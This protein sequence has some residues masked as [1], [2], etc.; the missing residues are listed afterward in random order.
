LRPGCYGIQRRIDTGRAARQVVE[1]AIERAFRE[2]IEIFE[3]ERRVASFR[4]QL[5]SAAGVA[6]DRG[7]AALLQECDAREW[8]IELA[9]NDE[10]AAQEIVSFIQLAR[11]CLREAAEQVDPSV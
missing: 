4:E 7:D 8:V 3:V 5:A 11:A 1:P 9:I 10:R 2:H 6:F